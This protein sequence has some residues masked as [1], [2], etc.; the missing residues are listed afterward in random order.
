LVN[1]E[2]FFQFPITTIT[3]KIE[4]KRGEKMRNQKDI[5]IVCQNDKCGEIFPA[6]KFVRG[7]NNLLACPICF[8]NIFEIF[9]LNKKKS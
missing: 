6:T 8:Q 2:S 5:T 7:E 1:A 3:I 4:H 9:G